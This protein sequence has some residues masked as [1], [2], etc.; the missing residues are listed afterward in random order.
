M[1]L[2]DFGVINDFKKEFSDIAELSAYLYTQ[3]SNWDTFFDSIGNNFSTT[4]KVTF[5]SNWNTFQSN[6]P[7]GSAGYMNQGV[8]DSFTNSMNVSKFICFDTFAGEIF[9]NQ[10]NKHATDTD[11]AGDLFN[12]FIHK[13]N[14]HFPNINIG[15]QYEFAKAGLD[16]NTIGD[17]RNAVT[18]K[19]EE[20]NNAKIL[21][22]E[23]VAN[24]NRE[25][26]LLN[27]TY[28]EKL[29]LE[30]PSKYWREKANNHKK[31]HEAL[32]GILAT[33]IILV[34]YFSS[35]FSSNYI[36]Y[37]DYL[38]AHFSKD[39]L[40]VSHDIT[41]VKYLF[42]FRLIIY[43]VSSLLI[44]TLLIWPIRHLV[45]M[46]ISENH[47]LADAKY[48]DSLLVTYLALHKK[49]TVVQSEDRKIALAAIFTL[50]QDGLVKDDGMP[51]WLPNSLFGKPPG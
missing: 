44:S 3:K 10:I 24:S 49:G 21:L 20:L 42:Y 38:T 14:G 12:Y 19:F 6:C 37:L 16:F 1:A 30:A 22:E 33:Y 9:R 11:S 34:T 41:V 5:S 7:I 35:L 29:R 40:A 47:L 45:R 15:L 39:I 48:K 28:N 8:I 32:I 13:T 36:S 46:I 4:W 23:E 51:N 2:L 26:E 27:A 25:L 50:P 17:A 43:L 31:R 18:N